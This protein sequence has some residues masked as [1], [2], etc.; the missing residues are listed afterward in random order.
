MSESYPERKV[1]RS[2]LRACRIVELVARSDTGLTLTELA[3]A[4]G[5]ATNTTYYLADTLVE[6]RVLDKTEHTHR[7]RLGLGLPELLSMHGARDRHRHLV[8]AVRDLARRMP[9]ATISAFE[10]RGG[11][12]VMVARVGP[13]RR[14]VVES[15]E[16]VMPPYTN[17]SS[18]LFLA[19]L[20]REALARYALR[21]P[22]A[23][24]AIG[25]WRDFAELEEC[26]SAVRTQ[27]YASVARD[28]PPLGRSVAVAYPIWSVGN[29]LDGALGCHAGLKEGE[30]LES[31][32]E[33]V[34]R[35]LR[36]AIAD[37]GLDNSTEEEGLESC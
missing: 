25:M 36:Q 26:L 13:P 19:T 35:A 5:L 22:F 9:A 2:V 15:P 23:E 30:D 20:S 6:M 16:N 34:C 28:E 8:D 27:G 1:V 10:V 3:D 17:A 29:Q 33:Q 4:L 21:H 12:M 31:Y 24:Y 7:Y 11:E 14:N 18:L 32:T 37:H